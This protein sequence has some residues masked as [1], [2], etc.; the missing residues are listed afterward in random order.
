MKIAVLNNWVPFLRGGAEHL[1]EALTTKLVEYGHQAFLVRVPFRWDP[2]AK[3][4]EHMVA[5]RAM[6]LPNFDRV[7][8]L[9]FP[10][11][12]IPHPNRVLWLL[13][14][15]RQVYDLWDTPYQGIPS[16]EEGRRIRHAII[17]S[18]N[19]F[20]REAKHIFTNSEITGERLLKFNQLQSTVLYPPLLKQD[21]FFCGDHGD[22]LFAPGR[23][24]SSKR[25]Q[26]IVRSM[27]Y[28][29]TDARL[30]IAGQAETATDAT[31]LTALIREYRLEHKV[32][33]INRFITEDEKA[34]WLAG[35]FACAYL[36][37]DEDSYG[38]VTLE[39]CLSK[40]PVITSTDSGGVLAL[41]KDGL[42]G[43]VVPPEPKALGQAI[44]QLF[45]NRAKT[46]AMGEAAFD[47]A[48]S[49]KINWHS[50]I[51]ALTQ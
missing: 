44:D 16:S 46:R 14:Q 50:V 39:S 20:L 35:A 32:Q 9:K 42:T 4:I 37:Y 3:I 7:I 30:V 26:L 19:E 47:R 45:E 28:C 36:P 8:G 29:R 5:C 18:D 24:N 43:L 41:V 2:P 11:Y 17:R 23:I 51:S 33:F 31:A 49:L 21:H 22:Y 6:R 12:Y 10:A 25:Q 1:A 15:F 13:H 40:K 38:Y 48:N 34:N 27:R